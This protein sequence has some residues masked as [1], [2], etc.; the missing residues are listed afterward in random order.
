MDK[1]NSV[2]REYLAGVRLVKALNRF[3]YE[4]G[5]FEDAN[6][7]L[8]A[9][10]EKA[11][12]VMAVFTPGITLTVNLGIVIVLWFGGLA[13][14]NGNLEVGKV[15]AFVNYMTQI[16]HSLMMISMVFNM[17]VRARASAERIDE[18]LREQNTMGGEAQALDIPRGEGSIVFENVSFAYGDNLQE[19]VL[20]DINLFCKPGETLGIIGSTGSGKTSLINLIP[21]FYDAVEGKVKVNGIDVKQMDVKD[22][23]DKI[24]VVPQRAVLFSGSILDNIKWG[25]ERAAMEAIIR[26]C[27]IAQAHDFITAL[28][29]QYETLLGQGGVNLSGGQK[30]RISIARAL[31]KNPEILILDD[32]TSAVDVTTEAKI[33]EGLRQYSKGLT[34]IIITQRITSVLTADKIAVLDNGSLAGL[35]T[36]AELL[37]DCEVYR[38]IFR[39]QIGKEGMQH[40]T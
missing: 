35:G 33:R 1:L 15:I 26:V 22:L 14:S 17:L 2:L 38:D 23:R 32:S 24:A 28:P 5:R 16:L 27:S 34:C 30:Q 21:R 10:T 25:N 40:G 20:K 8:A 12:R 36:H 6:Q 4:T 11:M 7:Y 29:K 3:E 13:V 9:T 37:R 31:I 39:S 19:L 18:V